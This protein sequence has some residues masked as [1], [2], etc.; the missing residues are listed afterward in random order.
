MDK[1]EITQAVGQWL[2]EAA[3]YREM[4]AAKKN[5]LGEQFWLGREHAL[6]ELRLLLSKET[7]K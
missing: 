3:H 1:Q 2:E 6:R 5:E 7:S 4:N